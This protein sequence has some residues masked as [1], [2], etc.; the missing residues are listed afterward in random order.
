MILLAWRRQW[1]SL[2]PGVHHWPLHYFRQLFSRFQIPLYSK[3]CRES[4]WATITEDLGGNG[5]PGH[6]S[7]GFQTLCRR[8]LSMTFGK[9]G[10]VHSL[11]NSFE[12]L[13]NLIIST[14][15][16]CDNR[17]G[18]ES[19]YR[20]DWEHKKLINKNNN[21]HYRSLLLNVIILWNW[22][23]LPFLLCLYNSNSSLPL[24]PWRYRK[25]FKVLKNT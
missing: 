5:L 3:G 23:N 17:M 10:M 11:M 6:V 19:P 20:G 25:H 24:P 14:C 21:K 22:G 2:F 4:G 1:H 12:G 16:V 13:P 7:V 15:W 9:A 8:C 18:T